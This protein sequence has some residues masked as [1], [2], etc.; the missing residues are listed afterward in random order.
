M[1]NSTWTTFKPMTS[2]KL[3]DILKTDTIYDDDNPQIDKLLK[4]HIYSHTIQ[5]LSEDETIVDTIR[6]FVIETNDLGFI[7]LRNMP[8]YAL[9]CPH[10]L[11]SYGQN[12]LLYG[13]SVNRDVNMDDT[14]ALLPD[15][16]LLLSLNTDTYHRLG[17]IGKE[18]TLNRKHNIINKYRVMIELGKDY[19]KPEKKNYQRVMECLKRT[20][21][22]CD[23]IL[24]W[25][26]KLPNISPNSL[27]QYFQHVKDNNDCNDELISK[28]YSNRSTLK[29]LHIKTNSEED[30]YEFIDWTSAQFAEINIRSNE[31]ESEKYTDIYCV[32]IKGFFTGT[33]VRNLMKRM[34][35]EFGNLP[36]EKQSMMMAMMVHGFEDSP[37]CWTGR[38]NEHYKDVSGEN[39]YGFGHFEA[40]NVISW[41]IADSFDF[42]IEKM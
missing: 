7:F 33:N 26:P 36:K 2:S 28:T 3:V 24:K 8:I 11:N 21:L 1:T 17:L 5:I 29:P 39:L 30:M 42:G 15:Q 6:K 9:I 37:Q 4:R 27:Q 20:Q 13:L 14:Y 41:V 38:N 40:G 16:T 23:F 35:K 25:E 32:D 10:F 34:K 12:G 31:N 19:F 18:S 22:K